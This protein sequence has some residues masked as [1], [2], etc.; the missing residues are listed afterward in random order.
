MKLVDRYLGLFTIIEIIGNHRQAY[1]LKLP[2]SYRIH[3]VFYISLLEPWY[4]QAGAVE[5]VE[6][7]KVKGEKEFEVELVLAHREGK[8]GREYLVR[9]KGFTL[10]DNT[11]EPRANLKYTLI[12]VQKYLDS[13]TSGNP[14][15]KR[16]HRR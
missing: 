14:A 7:I 13:E 12:E 1:R 3:N 9:W 8:K 4:T 10:A 5:E 16:R 15:P 2:P 6:P 11:W